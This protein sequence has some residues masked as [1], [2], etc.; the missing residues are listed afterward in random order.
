MS[1]QSNP[2]NPNQVRIRKAGLILR[3]L[4]IIAA[5]VVP[6]TMIPAIIYANVFANMAADPEQ[7]DEVIDFFYEEVT[8]GLNHEFISEDLKFYVQHRWFVTGHL[9]FATTMGCISIFLLLRLS[10][11]WIKGDVFSPRPIG[12]F[13]WMGILF[14]SQGAIGLVYGFIAPMSPATLFS[15]STIYELSTMM[16]SMPPMGGI[17]AGIVLLTLAWILD[18][19]R[20]LREEQELTV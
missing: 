12:C 16:V 3:I 6:L 13:R 11:C 10:S 20:Q 8:E 14:I 19:G 4:A 1:T 17:E 9:I 18:W 2:P 7:Y 5:V 15:A